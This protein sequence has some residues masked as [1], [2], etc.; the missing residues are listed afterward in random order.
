M[1]LPDEASQSGNGLACM[2]RDLNDLQTVLMIS[3]ISQRKKKDEMTKI[4][5]CLI[6]FTMS[7]QSFFSS[8]NVET[9]SFT[10]TR[11]A[12]RCVLPLLL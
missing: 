1:L 6:V 3:G 4:C 10:R 7:G 11:D 8:T 12:L 9:I 2:H 5:P